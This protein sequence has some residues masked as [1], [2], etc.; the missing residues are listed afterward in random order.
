MNVMQTM[1]VWNPNESVAMDKC[2]K[3]LHETLIS[4]FKVE[5]DSIKKKRAQAIA[6]LGKTRVLAR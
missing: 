5:A 3:Q 4:A 1:E 2:Q 6:F